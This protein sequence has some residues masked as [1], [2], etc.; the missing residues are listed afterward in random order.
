MAAVKKSHTCD[1]AKKT[2]NPEARFPKGFTKQG[3]LGT[4]GFGVVWEATSLSQGGLAVAMKQIAKRT[5]PTLS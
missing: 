1:R 3:K 5:C 2:G 4:G